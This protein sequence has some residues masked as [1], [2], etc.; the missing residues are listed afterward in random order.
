MLMATT[1]QTLEDLKI[2]FRQLVDKK[3]AEMK[4]GCNETNCDPE[5][6]ALQARIEY[7][8]FNE[9]DFMA[10]KKI[11]PL[12]KRVKKKVKNKSIT[13][14]QF[15]TSTTYLDTDYAGDTDY[16][17]FAQ[18]IVGRYLNYDD[19]GFIRL[20]KGGFMID[21]SKLPL[22]STDVLIIIN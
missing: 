8:E 10:N 16:F 21:P 7:I 13:Y 15:S 1:E 22:E 11:S 12:I 19:D 18:K 4:K 9:A 2:K 17:V 6:D 14:S 20:N 3:R 5:I